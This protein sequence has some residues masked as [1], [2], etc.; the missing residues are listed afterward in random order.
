MLAWLFLKVSASMVH[1]KR[2]DFDHVSTISSAVLS[3][4]VVSNANMS[5]PRIVAGII[6]AIDH[7]TGERSILCLQDSDIEA[8]TLLTDPTTVP[9]APHRYCR[10]SGTSQMWFW[11]N[12]PHRPI[13]NPPF[14]ISDVSG[15]C[16]CRTYEIS[17]HGQREI[18]YLKKC[19]S[20][21]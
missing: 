2:R 15:H 18:F 19:L 9:V 21:L 11:S 4:S 7:L 3:K 16:T 5:L 1:R 17:Q 10:P 6:T 20:W 8:L 14:W 13:A 12:I